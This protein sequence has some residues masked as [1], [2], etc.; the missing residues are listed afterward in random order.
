MTCALIQ[1]GRSFAIF[2]NLLG[3][4]LLAF[5]AGA[6][7]NDNHHTASLDILTNLNAIAFAIVLRF[8][9]EIV[10]LAVK[11]PA[12]KV[13]SLGFGAGPDTGTGRGVEDGVMLVMTRR[14]II[15][16]RHNTCTRDA[17][18]KLKLFVSYIRLLTLMQFP[19]WSAAADRISRLKL[20]SL[21]N[22]SVHKPWLSYFDEDIR[23][24]KT[25]A[26]NILYFPCPKPSIS[27]AFSITFLCP[28]VK[29]GS[30][31]SQAFS[32]NAR[33]PSPASTFSTSSFVAR[34]MC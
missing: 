32:P 6:L 33:I 31:T 10:G 7:P 14:L 24:L 28:I 17:Y 18:P 2:K 8:F 26:E 15:A 3:A 5:H 34:P 19:I 21:D 30:F 13:V 20:Q 11:N 29:P 25:A 12:G 22:T 1:V 9:R 4:R 23:L 27:F 16:R